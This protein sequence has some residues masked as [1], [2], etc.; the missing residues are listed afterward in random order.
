MADFAHVAGMRHYLARVGGQPAGGASVRFTD[1]I[2]QLCGAS[3]LPAFRRR[4][5]QG[6][7]LARRL[8]DAAHAGCDLAVATT[9]PGSGSM[10]NMQRQGFGLLYARA[11]W[12]REG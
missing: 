2:S 12:M 4:G 11:V 6:A 1:G 9:R 3:T 7:L 8:H 10:Q 5:I